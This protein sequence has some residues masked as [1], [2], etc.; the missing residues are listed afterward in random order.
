LFRGSYQPVAAT[1]PA[2]GHALAFAREG[3]AVTF[4]TR[5]PAGLRQAGGWRDTA[6]TL[7]AGGGWRDVLTGL[8]HDGPQVPVASLT[9]QLPVALL[10][11]D[12]DTGEAA[13]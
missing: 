1:G 2:A 3:R 7:P 13:G 5:L 6:V 10:V 11:P 12:A 9:R 4:A 8:H